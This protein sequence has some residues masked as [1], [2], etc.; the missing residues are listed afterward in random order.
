MIAD[1]MPSPLP[2]IESWII[3]ATSGVGVTSNSASCLD[4]R[5]M[6]M[7]LEHKSAGIRI[8][9]YMFSK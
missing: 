5:G 7:R 3:M 6:T 9:S 8:R 2:L 1:C 4:L